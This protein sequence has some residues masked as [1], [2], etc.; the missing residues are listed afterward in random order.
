MN[1]IFDI[2]LLGKCII[3]QRQLQIYVTG[4]LQ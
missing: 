2:D 3:F 1:E 4:L